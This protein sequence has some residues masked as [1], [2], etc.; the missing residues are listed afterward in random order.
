MTPTITIE[1]TLR[2]ALRRYV[3]ESGE[4]MRALSLRAGLNAKAISDLLAIPGITPRRTTLDAL[5]G[6]TGLDLGA[7]VGAALVT[8]ATLIDRCERMGVQRLRWLCR[9]AGW[10]PEATAVCRREAVE[11]LERHSAAA[12]GIRP[13]SFETYKSEALALVRGAAA[14]RRG[15]GVADLGPRYRT[16]HEALG[17]SDLP[18]WRKGIAGSFFVFLDAEGRGPADRPPAPW[19][20][21]VAGPAGSGGSVVRAVIAVVPVRPRR[22]RQGLARQES[23][24]LLLERAA[25]LLHPHMGRAQAR[26]L[27]PELVPLGAAH[28]GCALR[29]LEL[30]RQ[31][32]GLLAQGEGAA[33]GGCLHLLGPCVRGP[34]AVR[35][36]IDDAAL[37]A[38]RDR[39]DRRVI[40]AMKRA[41]VLDRALGREDGADRSQA[42]EIARK[43]LGACEAAGGPGG[44]DSHGYHIAARLALKGALGCERPERRRGLRMET[45]PFLAGC[46]SHI[47]SARTAARA[48]AMWAG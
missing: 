19:G 2:E 46:S 34:G 37:L 25:A 5:S 48:S 8:Y 10:V 3:A 23:R 38:C 39:L 17:K 45:G 27:L 6:A 20:G 11:F 4:S 7:A 31:S 18:A 26:H 21:R 13:R 16:I 40:V 43:K 12:A 28:L 15:R 1:A 9:Q 30:A 35:E 36:K 24:D 33:F 42:A 44:L 14:R 22:G 41:R 47:S 29:R 32:A